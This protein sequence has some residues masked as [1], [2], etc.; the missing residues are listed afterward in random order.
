[1]SIHPGLGTGVRPDVGILLIH[2]T[3]ILRY[4]SDYRLYDRICCLLSVCIR[5]TSESRMK[6]Q[7]AREVS[8]TETV[9]DNMYV[10]LRTN[11]M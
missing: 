6:R 4:S 3:H 11:S 9:S 2:D 8:E 1:M 7:T 10:T 5:K